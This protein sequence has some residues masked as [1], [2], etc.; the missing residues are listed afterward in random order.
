MLK[1]RFNKEYQEVERSSRVKMHKSGK[2]WVRTVMSQLGLMR[3]MGGGAGREK[4]AVSLTSSSDVEKTSGSAYLKAVI[5]V[6]ALVVAGGLNTQGIYAEGSQTESVTATVVGEDSV[7][8]VTDT[9]SVSASKSTS[10]SDSVSASE[11]TSASEL[12]PVTEVPA[13]AVETAVADT[14]SSVDAS[15]LQALVDDSTNFVNTDE[16]KSADPVYQEAYSAA[17]VQ[18]QSFLNAGVYTQ[19]DIDY[20]YAQLSALIDR[21]KNPSIDMLS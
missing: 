1:K 12:T 2:H 10:A 16:F 13:P 15:K 18:Y 20:G 11:S 14:T 17:I 6:G 4:V 8:I 5:V 19:S 9:N 7:G 3:I 21:I